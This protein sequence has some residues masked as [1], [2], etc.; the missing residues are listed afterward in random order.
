[1]TAHLEAI[2]IA[3]AH[4]ADMQPCQTALVVEGVGLEGDRYARSDRAGQVMLM[5]AEILDRLDLWPGGVREN[6]TTRGIDVMALQPGARLRIGQAVLEATGAAP[7]CN[8]NDKVRNEMRTLLGGQRGML[9]RVVQGGEI[10]TGDAIEI[11]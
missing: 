10:K 7:P 2:H 5:P 11:L 6:L 8:H 1:M 4:G 3:P 9:C